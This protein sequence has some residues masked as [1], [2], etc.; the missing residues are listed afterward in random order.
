MAR[1]VKPLL[2]EPDNLSLTP[3]P[4]GEVE[5]ETQPHTILLR[6]PLTSRLP[7]TCTHN[8]DKLNE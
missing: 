1:W 7:H 2:Y 4:H 6:L 5:R 3:G 8:N